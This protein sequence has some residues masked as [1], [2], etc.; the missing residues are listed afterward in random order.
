MDVTTQAHTVCVLMSMDTSYLT[1]AAK[2]L[3]LNRIAVE[4][5]AGGVRGKHSSPKLL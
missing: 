4:M 2:H 5:Q 1:V 3:F